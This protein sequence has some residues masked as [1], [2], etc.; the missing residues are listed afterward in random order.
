MAQFIK[1]FNKKIFFPQ[2][3]RS[4]IISATTIWRHSILSDL[5]SLTQNTSEI[6]LMYF[7]QISA[8][9]CDSH[10]YDRIC[11][12][13]AHRMAWAARR[14][15][16]YLVDLPYFMLVYD[17]MCPERPTPFCLMACFQFGT[18]RFTR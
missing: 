1:K 14:T 15:L 17:L 11:G 2:V 18:F 8:P 13:P 4:H 16:A 12:F 3:K 7:F 6:N 10:R 9:P 5:N